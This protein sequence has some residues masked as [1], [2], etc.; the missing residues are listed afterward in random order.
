MESF[1]IP[2]LF[3]VSFSPIL[4]PNPAPVVGFRLSSDTDV[5]V[6][7]IETL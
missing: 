1:S 7:V 3:F 6:N 4:S 2:S 5:A